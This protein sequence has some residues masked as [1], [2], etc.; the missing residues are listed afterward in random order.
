MP[1]SVCYC[2]YNCFLVGWNILR[3]TFITCYFPVHMHHPWAF[4]LNLELF[5]MAHPGQLFS[6][7]FHLLCFCA[8]M[9]QLLP[10]CPVFYL[11]M[12]D[13]VHRQARCG[14]IAQHTPLTTC[15][16]HATCRLCPVHPHSAA[17]Q[18]RDGTSD[19]A[20]IRTSRLTQNY[21][22]MKWALRNSCNH[23]Q[24]QGVRWP[25]LMQGHAK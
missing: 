6:H 15:F 2:F 14:S 5:V 23:W 1:R 12:F 17:R 24:S 21:V 10:T 22:G 18:L 4:V 8:N 20:C 9:F 13:C 11:L 7:R 25:W 16:L 19:A 3:C